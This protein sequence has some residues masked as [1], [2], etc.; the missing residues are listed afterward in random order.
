M[1]WN[2]RMCIM[3][4]PFHLSQ[5]TQFMRAILEYGGRSKRTTELF[6]ENTP[7]GITKKF[8]KGLKVSKHG[9]S[10]SN[11]SHPHT[12]TWCPSPPQPTRAHGAHHPSH[13]HT[14]TW[15]PSPLPPTHG[16]HHLFSLI[17]RGWRMSTHAT[18]HSS[19]THWTP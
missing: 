9:P 18:S 12:I 16:T 11:P 5:H 2:N 14:S 19:V 3:I 6:E 4:L 8:F 13:P 1:Y 7:L 17:H 15:R 10:H